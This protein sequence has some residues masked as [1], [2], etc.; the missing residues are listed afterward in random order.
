MRKIVKT[1][2]S[3]SVT[4]HIAGRRARP[5]SDA[6]R[7]RRPAW[8]SAWLDETRQADPKVFDCATV[9][10]IDV[11][12]VLFV[13]SNGIPSPVSTTS[14]GWRERLSDFR[15]FRHLTVT[16]QH[17]HKLSTGCSMDAVFDDLTLVTYGIGTRSAGNRLSRAPL[18]RGW[19]TRQEWPR[20]AGPERP[21]RW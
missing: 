16:T 21:W 2:V 13:P 7:N 14:W 1:P 5:G 11:E 3:G 17:L 18:G 20:V 6:R 9:C 8:I 10:D 4:A 15:L 19:V 12:P